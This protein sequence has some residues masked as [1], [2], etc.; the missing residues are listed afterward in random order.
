MSLTR[1]GIF[2]FYKIIVLFVR[3][4]KTEDVMFAEEIMKTLIMSKFRILSNYAA[5]VWVCII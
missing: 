2:T 4:M 5:P 3:C 1:G